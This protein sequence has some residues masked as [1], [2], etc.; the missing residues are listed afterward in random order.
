[1]TRRVLSKTHAKLPYLGTPGADEDH[2][3]SVDRDF[4]DLCR[5]RR[6]NYLM[7]MVQACNA[8]N[9]AL[10]A[11]RRDIMS[12]LAIALD[13]CDEVDLVHCRLF[14]RTVMDLA[15]FLGFRSALDER[16]TWGKAALEIAERLED[17][18][19]IAELCASTIAWPLLQ[20]GRYD[21]AR[22]YS[23]KGLEVAKECHDTTA[24]AR[25]AGNAARTLSGIAK[26]SKDAD[27]AYYWAQ[28]AAIHAQASKDGGLARGAEQDFGYAALL[29]GD[30][31]EAERRFRALAEFEEAAQDKERFA[32]RS[33]DLALA[34]VNQAIRAKNSDV[35]IS[36]C[37]RARALYE[38]GLKLAEEL[39]NMIMVGEA[40]V[41]LAVVARV[42]GNEEE[43]DRLVASGR[44][45]MHKL[46][47]LRPGRSEQFIF[48]PETTGGD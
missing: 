25:W 33:G 2:A 21:E 14:I 10:E 5:T 23:L 6:M 31:L 24:A 46:G 30:F 11:D 19:A 34:I 17:D 7:Q 22:Y 12:A 8:D 20:Q 47:V 40:E 48:F 36:L 9:D 4:D 38:R 35:R 39:G 13:R 32:N 41:G 1:M 43:Y 37:M 15:R 27:A 28:Q 29:R 3:F 18:L 42:L 16:V 44:S 26:E 45:R